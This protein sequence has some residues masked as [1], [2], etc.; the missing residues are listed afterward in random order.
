M[1]HRRPVE[2]QGHA[3]DQ[4]GQCQETEV[5][6]FDGTKF[7]LFTQIKRKHEHQIEGQG[8]DNGLVS[9][10]TFPEKFSDDEIIHHGQ[11]DC[12][13]GEVNPTLHNYS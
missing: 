11:Q 5:T 8:K 1:C 7:I 9:L 13:E 6:S 2:E 4:G 3:S 10:E 12:Q